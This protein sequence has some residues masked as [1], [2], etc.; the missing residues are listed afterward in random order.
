MNL[1]TRGYELFSFWKTVTVLIMVSDEVWFG[2][3]EN[4]TAYGEYACGNASDFG[5]ILTKNLDLVR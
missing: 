1:E 4:I 2:G 5:M 3:D